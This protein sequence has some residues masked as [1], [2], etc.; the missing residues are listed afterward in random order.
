MKENHLLKKIQLLT[1]TN[2]VRKTKTL[3]L[4]S[5]QKSYFAV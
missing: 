5:Q 2:D 1:E 3:T 4:N